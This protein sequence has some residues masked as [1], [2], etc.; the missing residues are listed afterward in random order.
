MSK[1]EIPNPEILIEGLPYRSSTFKI[2]TL[3]DDLPTIDDDDGIPL[4]DLLREH[5]T[6]GINDVAF[7]S[8]RLLHHILSRDRVLNELRKYTNLDAE[9]YIGYIQ[10]EDLNPEKK[11][12]TYLK[13]FALLVLLAKGQEIVNFVKEEVSDQ[14]L[15]LCRRPG[16]SKGSVDLG[17]HDD[18]KKALECLRKW[19]PH[20][21]ETFEKSQWELLIPYFDLKEGSKTRHFTFEDRIILP[22]CKRTKDLSATQPSKNEG[23][24]A[25]VSC[26]KIDPLSHGFHDLLKAVS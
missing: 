21:R 10:S 18:P 1:P 14:S 16:T 11:T 8:L 4:A 20:D 13:I 22:W 26:V 24:F 7:W 17:P 19:N 9:K 23:G 12:R 2:E 15:P 6:E 3:S 5:K 25:S